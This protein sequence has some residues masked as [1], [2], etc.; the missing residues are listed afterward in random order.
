MEYEILENSDLK[1]LKKLD[2]I[3]LEV[4]MY[5][6]LFPITSYHGCF[7]NQLSIH[8]TKWLIPGAW[9]LKDRT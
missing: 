3:Y 5:N 2:K 6:P 8:K 9:S 4:T 1:E 7:G